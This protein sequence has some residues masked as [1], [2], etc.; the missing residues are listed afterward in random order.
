MVRMM[1]GDGWP[2]RQQI[3]VVL[4]VLTR[5]ALPRVWQM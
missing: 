5:R 2:L 1:A 4:Q 3:A